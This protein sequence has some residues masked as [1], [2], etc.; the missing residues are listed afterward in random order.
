MTLADFRAQIKDNTDTTISEI[1]KVIAK[2]ETT[3]A[4]HSAKL[5][6]Y[7]VM[8]K[9]NQAQI[10][11]KRQEMRSARLMTTVPAPGLD[12]PAPSSPTAAWSKNMT[13]QGDQSESGLS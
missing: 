2:I 8:I 6:R 12:P 5:N 7:E 11:E 9:A 3:V 1:K 13:L 10:A 4:E